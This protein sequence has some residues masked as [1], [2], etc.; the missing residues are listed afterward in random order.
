MVRQ[1][2]YLHS[3]WVASSSFFHTNISEKKKRKENLW[4]KRSKRALGFSISPPSESCQVCSGSLFHSLSH[5]FVSLSSPVTSAFISYSHSL[6]RTKKC[7]R[8]RQLLLQQ[9]RTFYSSFSCFLLLFVRSPLSERTIDYDPVGNKEEERRKCNK[10][11]INLLTKISGPFT[12][13]V[14]Q[15]T[16]CTFKHQCLVFL[17]K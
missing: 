17:Q 7:V 6:P 12:S 15:Q 16:V 1:S 4:K 13:S 2:T 3:L 9:E 11:H 10:R 8:M 5:F 14:I